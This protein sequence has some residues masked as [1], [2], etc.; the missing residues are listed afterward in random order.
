[1]ISMVEFVGVLA[2][3]LLVA[4]SAAWLAQRW[5]DDGASSRACQRTRPDWGETTRAHFRYVRRRTRYQVQCPVTC[6]VGE[7][8]VRGLV[9]DMSREGWRIRAHPAWPVD[10]T[11]SPTVDLLGQSEPVSV[12]Q[13]VVRWSEGTEFGVSL[14]AVDL[15]PAAHLSNFFSTLTSTPGPVRSAA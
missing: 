8:E 12:A 15:A 7:T 4:Q 5:Q 14:L 13:A 11:M 9:V 2:M 6:R 1:M 3:A 10:T